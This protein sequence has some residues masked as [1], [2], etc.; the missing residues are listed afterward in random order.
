MFSKREVN[1]SCIRTSD[2]IRDR[3]ILVAAI[4]TSA[5]Y[6]AVFVPY[7]KAVHCCGFLFS[8]TLLGF[9]LDYAL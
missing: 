5:I 9:N 6:R 1:C 2:G 8:N 4:K 3:Q 7:L